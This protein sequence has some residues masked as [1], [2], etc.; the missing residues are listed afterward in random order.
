[1]CGVA[2][3]AVGAAVR[4][5]GADAT[6]EATGDA[7]SEDGGDAAGENTIT[8]GNFAFSGVTE[9]AV[10]TTV[11]VTNTDGTPHTWTAEDDSFDSGA[12]A[13]GESFE[14]TFTEAGDFAFFCNFHPSMT[15]T[16]TVTG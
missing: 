2:A 13:P 5:G 6:T 10:G 11:T 16:I 14:F 15:G 9:V 12:I 1:V 4:G 8:I 3:A 7:S